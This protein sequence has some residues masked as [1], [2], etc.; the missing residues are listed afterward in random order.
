M[1]KLFTIVVFIL[2]SAF[3][4]FSQDLINYKNGTMRECR[5]EKV[6]DT[7]IFYKKKPYTDGIV[8]IADLKDL[9]SYM[10]EKNKVSANVPK[11]ESAKPS[12]P[13][14]VVV[15]TPKQKPIITPVN[16]SLIR[17]KGYVEANYA[18]SPFEKNYGSSNTKI[19]AADVLTVSTSHG[20]LLDD[21]FV[22]IGGQYLKTLSTNG[23]NGFIA[24][25][26]L[27]YFVMNNQKFK[28]N[29]GAKAG[30]LQYS[31]NENVYQG[32]TPLGILSSTGG[33]MINPFVSGEIPVSN[34]NNLVVSLG[35]LFQQYK[36]IYTKNGAGGT[37]T[38]FNDG[39]EYLNFSVG[40][41]F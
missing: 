41:S 33:L 35:Y 6:T 3:N 14:V 36:V 9:E 17:Y 23:G 37:S 27:R 5:I 19:T 29:V 26:D 13:A 18:N 25:A 21:L 24:H 20:I 32:T 39:F 38:L 40:V 28:L 15:E 16:G 1:K 8:F 11:I 2:V 7:Q 34:A 22:G 31:M 4:L 30:F 12:P 10:I